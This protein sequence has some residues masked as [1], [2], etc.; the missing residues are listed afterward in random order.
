MILFVYY[1]T[2]HLKYCNM[3]AEKNFI[4]E[5]ELIHILMWKKTLKDQ[6]INTNTYLNVN[7]FWDLLKT[8]STN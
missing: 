2:L 3:L 8:Y 7:K 4:E 5:S 6:I 1:L